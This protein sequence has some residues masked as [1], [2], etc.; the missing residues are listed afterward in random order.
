MAKQ[1]K[2]IVAGCGGMSNTWFDYVS[3][4]ENAEIV[5][6]VDVNLEAAKA[7]VER[8]DLGV[9]SFTN[10][11]E[12]IMKTD[13]NLVFDITIP[14]AHKEIVITALEAGCNVFG[15]KPMAETLKDA[16]EVL[17]TARKTG[18]TYTVMQNRRYLNQIRTFQTILSNGTIGEIG[19]IHA[20]FFLGPNFGGFRDL[21]DHPLIVD[22]AIH[23]FDQ[24]RFLTGKDPVSVYC[25]EYNPTGSW[26]KGNA[27]AIC[28]FEMT[29][30]TVFS[31]RGSWSAI[32]NQ[33]SWE[34]DWRVTGSKGSARW[35]GSNN[36][37]CE[38]ID[39]TKPIE[40]ITPVKQIN[41]ES[42]KAIREGHWGC[43]D[44]MFQALEENRLAETDCRDNIKSMEMVF[45]AVQSAKTGKKV[46][47]SE[48]D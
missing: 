9:P 27:S 33:T 44:E 26:Y 45:G 25:H 8:R 5:G 32:G 31:Y 21:M 20:D 37:I 6:V 41:I 28:I 39:E 43:L 15:E 13:A 46:I 38:V 29:D 7:M 16:K 19:S 1:H 10:L 48:M 14:A 4:R 35:D 12:A 2:I 36:P 22:M 3:Q 42:E 17:R 47:I 23:T 34:S 24:A 11:S 30:G 18:N 40:F